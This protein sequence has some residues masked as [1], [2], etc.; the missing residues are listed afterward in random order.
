M[1]ARVLVPLSEPSA[2]PAI[3]HAV[4]IAARTGGRVTILGLEGRTLVGVVPISAPDAAIGRRRGG[5]REAFALARAEARSEGCTL[6]LV[7]RAGPPTTVLIDEAWRA[8]ADLVVMEAEPP[9]LPGWSRRVGVLRLNRLLPCPLT[10]VSVH[11]APDGG[12]ASQ[13]AA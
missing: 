7:T 9:W 4:R 5:I 6:D 13:L 1:S 12:S 11:D 2:L 8:D 3:G 10:L